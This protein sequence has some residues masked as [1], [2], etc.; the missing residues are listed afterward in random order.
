MVTDHAFRASMSRNAQQ[1]ARV[2]SAL[3]KR[4]LEAMHHNNGDQTRLFPG[5]PFPLAREYLEQTDLWKILS[6]MPKGCLLHAH[7]DAMIDADWL[8]EQ[9][10]DLPGYYIS[11]SKPLYTPESRDSAAIYFTY[12]PRSLASSETLL[13]TTSYVPFSQTS[14]RTAANSFPDGERA[15]QSYI[16]SRMT[17][18]AENSRLYHH[19]MQPIWKKFGSCFQVISGLLY[20]EPILRRALPRL[21]HQLNCDGIRYVELRSAFMQPWHR[22]GAEKPDSEFSH[23]F[24]TFAEELASYTAS[25]NGSNFWGARIIWSTVRFLSD[26]DIKQSMLE[27]IKLKLEYPAVISGYDFVGSEDEARSLLDMLPL[28]FYFREQCQVAGVSEGGLPLFLHAGECLGDGDVPDLNVLDAILL[29]ARRIGHGFSLYKHPL[30]IDMCKERK[31]LIESCPISNEVLRLTPSVMQHPVP[32]LLSRGVAVSL[33]NDDPAILGHG[34]ENNGLTH[35]Y[36]QILLASENF[37]LEGLGTVAQ[38]SI[39]WSAMQDEPDSEWRRGLDQM[40]G[41][42]VKIERHALWQQEWEAW[43][44]WVVTQFG[45]AA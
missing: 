40:C 20:T 35:E 37:G 7:L 34:D 36:H 18:S 12:A 30:L 1:A 11:S 6:R 27:C 14:V 19:G 43:C 22:T 26:V 17:I 4:E 44:K 15:F 5:M 39:R 38:N 10:L 16:V 45:E 23:F 8:L 21:F 3:R 2:I 13:W 32:A 25:Q 24:S 41:S 31:I 9:A 29:G 28:F 42:G 33:N